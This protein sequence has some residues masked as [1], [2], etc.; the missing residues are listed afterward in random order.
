LVRTLD[1]CD[2]SGVPDHPWFALPTTQESRRRRSLYRQEANRKDALKA[3]DGDYEAFLRASAIEL[4][5]DPLGVQDVERV[6]E[7]SQRTNQLNFTGRKF[8]QDAVRSILGSRAVT[9]LCLRCR[10]RFGDYGL[11]GFAAVNIKLGRVEELFLSCRIQRKRVEHALFRWLIAEARVHGAPSLG[12]AHRGTGRNRAA[13]EM[14]LTLG[15]EA[16][17][18]GEVVWTRGVTADL[19]SSDIVAVRTPSAAAAA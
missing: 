5:I 18:D 11:I 7:L 2:V 9:G 12:V 19:E 6:F 4:S 13:Q 17:K 3:G 14:L 15:F 16:P 10:D 1:A 8:D